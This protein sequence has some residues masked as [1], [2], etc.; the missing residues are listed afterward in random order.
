MKSEDWARLRCHVVEQT[1]WTWDQVGQLRIDAL[2]ALTAH[3][4]DNPPLRSL[5]QAIASVLGVTFKGGVQPKPK[6]KSTTAK[7]KDVP[8]ATEN[9]MALGAMLGQFSRFAG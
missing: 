2:A 5:V 1:G 6:Q 4:A 7:S 8:L 9:E 3:W